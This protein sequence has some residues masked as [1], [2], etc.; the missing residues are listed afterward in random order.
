MNDTGERITYEGGADREPHQGKGRFDWISPFGLLR[1][2]EVEHHGAWSV[3]G[4]IDEAFEEIQIFRTGKRDLD[5]LAV[6]AS[7]LFWSAHWELDDYSSENMICGAISPSMMQRLADW[8]EAGG[9]KYGD[10]NWEKGM[11]YEHPLDSCLRHLNK[12]CINMHDEDHLAAALWNLFALM[13]YEACHMDRFDNIPRYPEA[14]HLE[15][16]QDSIRPN[17]SPKPRDYKIAAV[18]FDGCLCENAWPDIGNPNMRLIAELIARRDAGDKLILWT[19]REGEK[20]DEAV[21]WCGMRGLHFDAVNENLP[22]MNA[23]YGNDSRKVGADEYI[24]DKAV[25]RAYDPEGR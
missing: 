3:Q 8:C 7:E 9:I 6:A 19:C 16:F 10:R 11:P 25:C 18:D 24:D 1:V 20:L 15:R 21:D 23:F 2:I 22:E 14:R 5:Y 17:A 13:H 12:F 4:C